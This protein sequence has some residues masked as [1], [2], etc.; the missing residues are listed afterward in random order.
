MSFSIFSQDQTDYL[1]Q[2]MFFGKGLNVSR[3]DE[4]K[5]PFID[6]NLTDQQL[7]FFWRPEE[8]D[9]SKDRI[10]YNERLPENEKHIFTSNLKYQTL[11][12]SC[13]GRGIEQAFGKIV[14]IP[15][16]ENWFLTWAFSETIHSRSYT[17]IIRN[18]LANPGEIFDDIVLNPEITGRAINLTGNYDRF[19]KSVDLHSLFGEGHFE[20]SKKSPGGIILPQGFEDIQRGPDQMQ[21][22]EKFD[23]SMPQM[24]EDA[25]YL[26]GDINCLE[27]LRFYVS[28]ACSFAFA[29]RELMEGNAKVIK[30]ICRDESLHKVGTTYL[31]NKLADGSEGQ[32]WAKIGRRTKLRFPELVRSVVDQEKSWAKYLFKDGAMPGI[33][34]ESMGHY[35]EYL[36]D[37]LLD[38][39]GI[40]PL[41]G[42]K[43]NPFP[44]MTTY[45]NSEN[46]Q[47]A[48]QEVEISAYRTADLSSES[49]GLLDDLSL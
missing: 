37:V 43:R 27:A 41:Y 14:S 36:A 2:S 5:Y 44:W 8:I 9:I 47:P 4:L 32:E 13:Q 35:M 7:A 30:F 40:A 11:L 49:T 10:D 46:V 26:L 20:I 28:F 18:L 1:K 17:H 6:S 38:Q 42:R 39:M 33:N 22:V 16:L 21:L 12:D 48:P 45:T 19:I 34:L 29:E 31:I 3:F 25:F 15:E 23:V 24:M